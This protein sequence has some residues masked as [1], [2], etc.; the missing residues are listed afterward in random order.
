MLAQ[1][2]RYLPSKTDPNLLVGL[3]TSDDAAVYRLNSELATIQTVDFFTPM[4][5]D[6][7]LFGQIAAANA[8]SDIYAM[9][10]TPLLALNIVCFPSCLAPEIL[11]EILRGGADKVSEA[12]AIIAGGHSV[13]D[14]EPKYGL[15]VTGLVHP[16]KVFSNGSAQAG[17]L[18]I[19][20]KPL[21]TGI[22]N[23]AIKADMVSKEIYDRAVNTMVTLNKDAAA[24]M[25]GIGASACTDITGFG[26]L[27]HAAEMAK[28]SGL[29]LTV[30]AEEVPILPGVKELARMGIIP[31]GAYQNRKHL[32][33]SIFIEESVAREEVDIL[34]DP[35]T[36]GGLLIA[37]Q[38]KQA[39]RLLKE[40]HLRGVL[41]ARVVGELKALTKHLISIVRRGYSD[42]GN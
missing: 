15:A 18:L 5:D 36:S 30:F 34:F 39:N 10:G 38:P 40:L 22:I 25:V 42:K 17:D 26:F 14:D 32:G 16:E 37:V 19:L 33:E 24:A 13:Q 21:G 28:A 6:P 41:D 20:T 4:V 2:L 12:G 35:Q 27:G 8:L 9:G 7:Y 11:G 31:G 29:S 3:D 1:V 23:T